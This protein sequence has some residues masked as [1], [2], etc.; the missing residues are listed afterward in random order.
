MFGYVVGVQFGHGLVRYLVVYPPFTG[1]NIRFHIIYR[2]EPD[3]YKI[4]EY[5]Q[6]ISGSQ[7]KVRK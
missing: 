7:L 5:N 6:L 2:W 1:A 3:G 4:S